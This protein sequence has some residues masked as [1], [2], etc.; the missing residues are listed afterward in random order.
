MFRKKEDKA[1][2]LRAQWRAQEAERKAEVERLIAVEREQMR[3][4]K[5]SRQLEESWKKYVKEQERQAKELKK[6]EEWLIKHDEEI[7]KLKFKVGQ[8]ESDIAHW[9]E[10]VGN[11]YALL[12][13]VQVELDQAIV[14]GKTQLKLQ[15]QVITL[16]NQIHAAENRIN[17]ATFDR[18]TAKKK[19]EE[20]S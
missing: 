14:G 11:L 6:H 13:A 20:A 9:K 2:R 18:D 7:A 12:D 10:Q 1:E 16:N 15:K 3:M 17:K 4:E 19:M 8:A 5:Q